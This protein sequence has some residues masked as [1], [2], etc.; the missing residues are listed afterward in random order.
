[1]NNNFL[2]LLPLIMGMKNNYNFADM[3]TALSGTEKGGDFS[4]N[5]PMLGLVM[6]ML[7][8]NKSKE[9]P[10]EKPDRDRLEAIRNLSGQEVTDALKILLNSNLK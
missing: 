3:M 2:A 9:P 5:N 7:R 1:M 8:N 4:Q 10:E 6:N